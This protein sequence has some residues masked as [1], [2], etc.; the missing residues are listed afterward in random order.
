M[1]E[2]QDQAHNSSGLTPVVVQAPKDSGRIATKDLAEW[3]FRLVAV[4]ALPALPWAFNL[5][6]RL[7]VLEATAARKAEVSERLERLELQQRDQAI[8]LRYIKAA[9]A[10][11][12]KDLRA[13][14]E[15]VSQLLHEMRTERPPR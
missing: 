4:I 11:Q 7:A 3:G 13:M 8:E 6:M 10:E 14:R 9:Q 5:A 1:T 12:T 2:Q 15:M